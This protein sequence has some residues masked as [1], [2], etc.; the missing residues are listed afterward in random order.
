MKKPLTQVIDWM[1]ALTSEKDDADMVAT[2]AGEM[3]RRMKQLVRIDARDSQNQR[4]RKPKT[5]G[6]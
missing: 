3:R 5:K 6:R 2:T 4:K 1:H